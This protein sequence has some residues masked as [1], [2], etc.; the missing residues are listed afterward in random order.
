[1]LLTGGKS[2]RDVIAFPKTQSGACLMTA[3]PS[4]APSEQLDE[5]GIEWHVRKTEPAVQ[6]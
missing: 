6:T 2:I 3:A 4:T 5:L 1:M